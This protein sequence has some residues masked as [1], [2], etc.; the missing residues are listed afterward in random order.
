VVASDSYLPVAA[1][2]IHAILRDTICLQYYGVVS[3]V[4]FGGQKDNAYLPPDEKVDIFIVRT[5]RSWASLAP[6]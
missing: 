4:C 2:A 6:R 3:S 5:K 1:V